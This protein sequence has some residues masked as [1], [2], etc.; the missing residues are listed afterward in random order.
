MAGRPGYG[1]PQPPPNMRNPFQNPPG[2]GGGGYD[3]ESDGGSMYGRP[4]VPQYNNS[5]THL[6]SRDPFGEWNPS[7]PSFFFVRLFLENM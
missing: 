5:S 2:Y 1:G 4:G 7:S 3:T 6:N